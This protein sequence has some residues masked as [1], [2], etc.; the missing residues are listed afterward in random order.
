MLNQRCLL[1]QSNVVFEMFPS[2]KSLFAIVSETFIAPFKRVR[3]CSF[4]TS[5]GLC[6]KATEIALGK[7]QNRVTEAPITGLE[8]DLPSSESDSSSIS[9]SGGRNTLAPTSETQELMSAIRTGLDSLF[10]ASIFIRKFASQDKR[11]RAAKAALFG[12][13]ADIMYIK[14]RYPLLNKNATLVA[15]LGEANARRRQYF[16]YRRE[17]DER[18]SKVATENDLDDVKAQA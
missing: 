7:R 1:Y 8:I 9:R 3:L 4:T 17:L 2:S 16:L 12:N 5:I 15:R 13:C 6:Y 14:D 10:K 11:L 18:L